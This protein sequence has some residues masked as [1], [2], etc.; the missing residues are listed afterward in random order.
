MQGNQLTDISLTLGIL[1][2]TVPVFIILTA[3]SAVGV[4]FKGRL[5]PNEVPAYS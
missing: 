1:A 4:E 2:L 3:W 5:L